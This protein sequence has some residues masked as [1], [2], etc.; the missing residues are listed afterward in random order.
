LL[1]RTAAGWFIID[2]KTDEVRSDEEARAIIE[3]KGYNR[4]VER[5]ARAISNQLKARAEPSRSV[6]AKTRLVFLNMKD[7]IAIFDL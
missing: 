1:Y 2:F 5:Y 6:K 7:N 4:Q 3:Q